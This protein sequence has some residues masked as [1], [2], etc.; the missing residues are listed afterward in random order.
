MLPRKV[1]IT[2]TILPKELQQY[3]QFTNAFGHLNISHF[4]TVQHKQTPQLESFSALLLSSYLNS[5][6]KFLHTLYYLNYATIYLC[7]FFP[8]HPVHTSLAHPFLIL[9]DFVQALIIYRN[10]FIE[11]RIEPKMLSDLFL[12]AQICTH[13]VTILYLTVSYVFAHI[14]YEQLKGIVSILLVLQT[15]LL[16]HGKHLIHAC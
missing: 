12:C 4:C 8:E 7:L 10:S 2:F 16:E 5:R 15:C 11:C 9:P 1:Q 6:N 3:S 13:L 14:G